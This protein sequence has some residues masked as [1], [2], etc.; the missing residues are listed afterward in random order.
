MRNKSFS[1]LIFLFIHFV[2]FSNPN[3]IENN[4][5]YNTHYINGEMKMKEG[6]YNE[7]INYFNSAS[8]IHPEFHKPYYQ[9]GICYSQLEDYENAYNYFIK[10]IGTGCSYNI[11]SDWTKDFEC[12][13]YYKKMIREQDSL[14]N[15]AQNK[16]DTNFSNRLSNFIK[17]NIGEKNFVITDTMVTK[18]LIDICEEY[19]EFPSYLNVGTEVYRNVM[20]LISLNLI[21]M[22]DETYYEKVKKLVWDG[23]EKGGV[24]VGAYA[25]MEDFIQNKFDKPQKY[26]MLIN[27]SFVKSYPAVS[28]LNE[29]R[30]S[31]GLH[32]IELEAKALNIDLGKI[33]K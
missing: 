30:K 25:V 27:F 7:A 17:K 5:K 1:I 32:S 26:G 3:M 23:V 14:L 12:S 11:R 6:K 8:A 13:Q 18:K 29:N 2:C 19:G 20:Y 33:I 9:L 15:A 21:N 31:I 10:M 28:E 24:E 22:S 4:L 16:F